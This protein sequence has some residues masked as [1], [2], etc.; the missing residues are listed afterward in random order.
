MSPSIAS[1]SGSI[2]YGFYQGPVSGRRGGLRFRWAAAQSKDDNF[3]SEIPELA[4]FIPGL[5]GLCL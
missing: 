1:C 3:I 4:E 2:F 5:T